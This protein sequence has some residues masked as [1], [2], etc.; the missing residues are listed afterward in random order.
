MLPSHDESVPCG[1]KVNDGTKASLAAVSCASTIFTLRAALSKS[2]LF[3]RPCSIS[4]CNCGSVNTSRQGRL[5]KL[6][7]SRTASV[8][9]TDAVS[10]TRPV[11]LTSGRSYLL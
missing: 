7:V 6:A 3:S 8:S 1:E 11:V 9:L 2:T 4:A 10:R 5:P